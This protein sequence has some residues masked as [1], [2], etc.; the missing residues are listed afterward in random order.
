MS[1]FEYGNGFIVAIAHSEKALEELLG[2]EKNV[3]YIRAIISFAVAYRWK[4]ILLKIMAM[5]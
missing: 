5:E 3:L 1:D 2:E 4:H